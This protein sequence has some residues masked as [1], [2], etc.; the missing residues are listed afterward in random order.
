MAIKRYV[1]EIDTTISN[2]FKS[3]LQTRGTGSNMGAADTL[4]V[5]S[6]YGQAHT[7]SAELS[8]ILVQFPVQEISS[9]RAN[10]VI[11]GSGSV[12]F[13]LK[14]YN[15]EHSYTVPSD[16][17]LEI[18]PVASPWKEG[19]GLD[20]DEY[21]DETRDELEGAT[22]L[23]RSNGEAWTAV[24]GDFEPGSAHAGPYT[25][26]FDKGTEDLELDIS[27]LVEQWLASVTA[28]NS[29]VERS[30]NGVLIKLLGTHEAYHSSSALT[31]QQDKYDQDSADNIPFNLT[32]SKSSYYTK[33][34]FSRTS[35]FFFK[36]PVIEA[37]WDDSKKDDRGN[38]YLKSVLANTAE[39]LNTLYLYNFVRGKLRDIPG[40]N[41][42]GTIYMTL[43]TGTT[44]PSSPAEELPAGGD[45]PTADTTVVSGGWVDVGI[46]TASLMATTSLNSHEY[47]FD[48]WKTGETGNTLATGS[49][50]RSRNFDGYTMNPSPEYVTT[51]TNLKT[52]YSTD[53]TARIRVHIREKDWCPTIYTVASKAIENTIIEDAYY[54]ITRVADDM[55]VVGFGTGAITP[56][57][58]GD[59]DSYT[60]LSFDASGNY[61]DFDMSLLERG[62]SYGIRL[63][64][65]INDSYHEQSDVFKFRVE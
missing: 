13:Y 28:S 50:F 44:D 48:V 29:T 1:A 11:P 41:D 42:D 4:E 55:E 47:F 20:M 19:S 18:L 45:V 57:N 52:A 9:S 6:V 58:M 22:W 5:F 62:Y 61:F 64:Y 33:K 2:A 17:T 12:N 40:L 59:P 36:R 65:Y 25:A 16:Y 39:N 23:S 24:G 49:R 7:S 8:R 37:R 27:E 14:M 53:E 31:E 43:H 15:A 56:Q 51:A 30:N 34:F 3:D 21:S 54:R 10:S 46:Y 38:F 32:G 63:M 60:R 35:E 26:S